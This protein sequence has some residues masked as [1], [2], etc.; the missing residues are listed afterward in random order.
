LYGH[1]K[2]MQNWDDELKNIMA[3]KMNDLIRNNNSGGGSGGHKSKAIVA[4]PITLTDT[5]FA[6]AMNKYPLFVVDFWAPWC[7]PCRMV[8]PL[9]E[10][11]ATELAG[12]VVF[13]KL[14]VD[15][16]P[17]TSSAFGIQ[18]IPSIAIF[19][20]GRHVDGFV[21][22]TSK[23]Q[24]QTRILSHIDGSGSDGQE[25]RSSRRIYG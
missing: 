1:N 25:D 5:N 21:G 22:V 19:K 6:E 11:L 9:I 18:S 17:M 23:S 12:E 16:N 24:M 15:E 3:R 13:G 14:N 10:Q 7:G 20:N 8:S 4:A 2:I